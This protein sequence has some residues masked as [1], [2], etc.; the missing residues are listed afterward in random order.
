MFEFTLPQLRS[1]F[2]S[3]LENHGGPGVDEVT[4]DRFANESERNLAVLKDEIARGIYLPLPLLQIL[5]AK[6]NGEPRKL[7]IPSVRDRVA[8]RAALDIIEP[9]LEK[10]FEPCSFAYRKGRSIRQVVD[11]IQQ[12]Y[13]QGFQWLVNADIDAFFDNVNHTI[14]EKKIRCFVHDQRMQMLLM[15]WVRADVW[16]GVSLHTLKKGIPQGS[17]VSPVLANLF[18]DELD[19]AMLAQG[20]RYIRY[21]DDYVVFAKSRQEAFESLALSKEVLAKMHLALDDEDVTNFDKG[22]K[23]LGVT[24]L[25]SM[26]LKPFETKRRKRKVLHYPKPLDMEA[27]RRWKNER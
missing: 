23:Y 19:E 18:L 20:Y 1:S 24:F 27:W 2:K 9:L 10:E 15:Q 7:C 4:T 5:V 25:R 12:L 13:K 22:F 16:D 17:A 14:L 21:A 6:K 3:V 11:R 26:V 8:Q